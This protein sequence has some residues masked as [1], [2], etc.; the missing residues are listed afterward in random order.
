MTTTLLAQTEAHRL[1][2]CEATITQGL[3][4]FYDVGTALL[5]IRDSRLY[6]AE[7]PTFE[8]YCRER[9]GMERRRAYQLIEAAEAF[10]S[11]QN[12]THSP[13]ANEAQ[14]RPLAAVAP[15][16][17]AE[18]LT[19]AAPK[20][21]QTQQEIEDLGDA[22]LEEAPA[23]P[24]ETDRLRDAIMGAKDADDLRERLLVIWE[25][26]T[27]KAFTDTLEKAAF[28]ARV[29]GYVSADEGRS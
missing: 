18:V 4:T 26:G 27:A 29:I 1:A 17:R 10:E 2:A 7:H 14:A 12:F 22:L 21:T 13:P 11:V 15:E 9:W 3:Q 8:A 24:L 16:A 25:G 28:M 5:E 23:N 19:L 20:F 6:R